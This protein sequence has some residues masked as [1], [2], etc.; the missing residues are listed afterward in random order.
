MNDITTRPLGRATTLCHIPT[1]RH[2]TARLSIVTIRPAD[3][4][5]SP[6]ATLLFGVLRRGSEGYPCLS[7]LN[8]A[9]DELYGTTLTIRNYLWGDSHII[10]FTAE[11][12]EDAYLP[13]AD[14]DLDLLGGVMHLLA[15]LLLHPLTDE[16]GLLRAD[17][18]EAEVRALCDSLRALSNDTRTY[19]AD[20]FRR[21]MC[22]DEPYGLSVG[23][24]VETVEAITPAALTEHYRRMLS[25]CRCA[26]YYVGQ[27]SAR[28]VEAAWN[29]SFGGWDPAPIP[30]TVTLP[31]PVPVAPRTHTEDRAVSQGKLCIGWSC[32]ENYTTL[33]PAEEAAMLVLSELFGVMQSAR[34][35][36]RVR[37]ELG[38]CYYCDGALDLTKG[39]LW[40]ASGIRPDRRA[41]AEAAIRAELSS[42]AAGEVTAEEVATARLSLV[43][44][45]L[46]TEDSQGA[47]ES[48]AHRRLMS[49]RT[50]TIPEQIALIEA[51]TPAAVAEA[52]ARF[53]PDTVFFL[54][55]TGATADS[56]G[57]M[58]DE[59]D[60]DDD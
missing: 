23:G 47:L 37:E 22:P 16:N 53:V 56:T 45:L 6:T 29:A 1:D 44:S 20:R 8:R 40:V 41:E 12:P 60:C 57:D 9:L 46:E 32:G 33:T 21:L 54:N 30:G 24:T 43:N 3:A 10:S 7:R 13:A 59:E 39:I 27:A 38:L 14:R 34:L 48:E 5:E 26:V 18:V 58:D 31:H 19:A 49:G 51:V 17:A 36:R 28:R 15:S 42:I 50:E 52:A 25:T 2:K 55:A 4:L 35:F 11:M